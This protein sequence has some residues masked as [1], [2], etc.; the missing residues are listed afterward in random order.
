VHGAIDF[1]SLNRE[2]DENESI[3]LIF[4]SKCLVNCWKSYTFAVDKQKTETMNMLNAYFY[5][6]Y[7]YFAATCGAEGRM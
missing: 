1:C 7:F 5:G 6:F 2:I 3:M 4:L